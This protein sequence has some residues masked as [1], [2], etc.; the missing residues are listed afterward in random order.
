MSI[1]RKNT[2]VGE[3]CFR[4]YDV[5]TR[6]VI[7]HQSRAL[8]ENIIGQMSASVNIEDIWEFPVGGGESG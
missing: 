2:E 4:F 6:N 7:C 3:L 1:R 8:G 5:L